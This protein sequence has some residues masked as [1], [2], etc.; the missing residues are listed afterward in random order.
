MARPLTMDEWIP[1]VV[2]VT[3]LLGLWRAKWR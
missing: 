1:V 3:L 2:A